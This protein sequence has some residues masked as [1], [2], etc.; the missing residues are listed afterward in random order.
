MLNFI[1]NML[2]MRATDCGINSD[3]YSAL[4]KTHYTDCLNQKLI[5]GVSE[6]R[7]TLYLRPFPC[8]LITVQET[9][10]CFGMHELF[11]H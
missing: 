8:S 3:V 5:F 10:A 4:S 7:Q 1:F 9:V 2:H 11:T 6:I